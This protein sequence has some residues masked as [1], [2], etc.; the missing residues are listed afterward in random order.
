MKVLVLANCSHRAYVHYLKA[1]HP[2][3]DVRAV[4]I[5]QANT[6]LEE[7]NAKFIGF[8]E[9]I[10]LFVGLTDREPMQSRVNPAARRVFLPSFDF[11]GFHPDTIWLQEV[12]SPMEMG[13]IHSRIAASAYLSGQSPDQAAQ[14]F[15]LS[16]YTGLG[17]LEVYAQD[18]QRLLQRFAKFDLDIAA[19]FETWVQ[20]GNFLYTPNHPDIRVFF[21]IVH[22]GM[23]GAG[24]AADIPASQLASLR[25]ATEDYLAE[26]CIW[27]VYPEIAAH[28]GIAATSSRWRT[29]AAKGLGIEF[30]LNEML[31]KSWVIYQGLPDQHAAMIKVLGG[32]EQVARYAGV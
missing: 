4:V 9:A 25:A 31:A 2:D 26:G 10:E 20:Q 16:H 7:Q 5:P 30:D 19:L 22:L 32:P 27:P 21:D 23:T 17:Y 13:V 18:K 24:L 8:I 29:S 28:F 12:P 3:W 14:L 6:W 11:N 1:T 15:N